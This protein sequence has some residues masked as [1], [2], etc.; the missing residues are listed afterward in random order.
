M[1]NARMRKPIDARTKLG[2][3]TE[4]AMAQI[5]E[6][7]PTIGYLP[8]GKRPKRKH[9]LVMSDRPVTDVKINMERIG[10]ADPIGFLAALLHG[11]PVQVMTIKKSADG[12][13]EAKT[14][15]VN[16]ELPLRAH[17]AKYFADKLVPYMTRTRLADMN[18]AGKKEPTTEE[19]EMFQR[20]ANE[21]GA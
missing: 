16:A 1:E 9:I 3:F 14:E 19:E 18:A 21:D 13:T 10:H 5:E 4:H 17:L 6:V 2:D 12:T 7:L 11:Q 15:W 8:P 20:A